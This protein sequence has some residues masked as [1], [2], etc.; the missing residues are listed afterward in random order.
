M[1]YLLALLSVVVLAVSLV[2]LWQFSGAGVFADRNAQR[3]ADMF[4]QGRQKEALALCGMSRIRSRITRA[5]IET[6]MDHLVEQQSGREEVTRIAMGEIERLSSH[7]RV[8]ELIGSLAPLLGL[9]GTVLGMIEAFQQMET[10]GAQVDPSVLSGGIW[11]ALLTTAVGLAVAIP[12]VTLLNFFERRIERIS[13]ELEN[14][15][16]QVFL[17]RMDQQNEGRSDCLSD[18]AA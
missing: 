3:A 6:R 4:R 16:A 17:T 10:A 2:K 18:K 5:A 8:L 15:I 11:L 9:F 13:H 1:V 7:L 14:L 12:T